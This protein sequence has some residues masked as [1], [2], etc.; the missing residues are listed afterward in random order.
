MKYLQKRKKVYLVLSFF[1]FL[2]IGVGYSLLNATLNINGNVDITKNTWDVYFSNVVLQDGSVEATTP[3]AISEGKTEVTFGA[4]LSKP[5]DMY[6][7]AVDVVNNGTIDAMLNEVVKSTLTS[8]QEKYLTFSVTYSDGLEISQKDSLKAGTSETILV[9]VQY[10]MDIDNDELASADENLTLSVSMNYVQ[11]DGSSVAVAQSL[12]RVTRDQAILDN[13]SSTYVSSSTG[14]NFGSISSDTNGKGVY[15]ISSTSN[16]NYPINYYR[17]EVE[18]NNVIFAGFCWKM[19]RTTD[20][21][22]VKMIYNGV[23]SSSNTCSNSGTSTQIGTSAFNSTATSLADVGYMYG[24]RY[25][26]NTKQ[27]TTDVLGDISIVYGNDVTYDTTTGKYT[28]LTTT[29]SKVS[30]WS[31]DFEKIVGANGYHYTCFNDSNTC[32]EVSYIYYHASTIST[33]SYGTSYYINLTNGKKINDAI[34]D[35]FTSDS[36]SA[37]KTSIDTWYA[38]NMT[39]YTT[40][41][42]DTVWCNDRSISDYSGWD[43]DSSGLGKNLLFGF[44]E[45]LFSTYEPTVNCKNKNDAFTVADVTKGNGK[46]TYPVGLLTGDEVMYAGGADGAASNDY[47]LNTDARF[48]LNAPTKISQTTSVT[49]GSGPCIS[50]NPENGWCLEYAFYSGYLVFADVTETLGVRPAISLKNGIAYT[51]GD[52]TESSPYIVEKQ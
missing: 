46:L 43:K 37:I 49:T 52:G 36:N 42:E 24:A 23:P 34:D 13:I 25:E 22:G 10:N 1:L 21:G 11:D 32:S 19:V 18:N 51:S 30:E 40:M 15:T 4:T 33:G 29:T 7:F 39:D 12:Y 27:M 5:G 44:Y 6:S 14:V 8:A 47:Y 41:L 17:G 16:S 3:V 28:L 31:T 48:W 50:R 20:T 35:M 9:S 2:L 45:R 38:S 26:E